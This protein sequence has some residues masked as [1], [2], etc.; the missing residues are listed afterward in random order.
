[1]NISFIKQTFKIRVPTYNI[2]TNSANISSNFFIELL[3]FVLDT[4]KHVFENLSSI[5]LDKG[6]GNRN[7]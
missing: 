5:I 2:T 1:M 7:I 4:K 3:K 6:I